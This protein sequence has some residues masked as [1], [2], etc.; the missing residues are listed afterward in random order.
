MLKNAFLNELQSVAPKA[1][2]EDR[3]PTLATPL[4]Q[5][6]TCIEQNWFMC[7]FLIFLNINW[8]EQNYIINFLN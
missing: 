5:L 4:I 7:L 6:I 8:F 3:M 1:C 2:A